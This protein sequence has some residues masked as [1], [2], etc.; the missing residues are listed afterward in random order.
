MTRGVGEEVL[1]GVRMRDSLDAGVGGVVERVVGLGVRLMGD[2]VG[3]GETEG[4]ERRER[5]CVSLALRVGLG[6]VIFF[7]LCLWRE[8][9]GLGLRVL[10]KEME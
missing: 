1:R 9:F 4:R 10:R 5:M 8:V 3:V 6:V 2:V 7:E